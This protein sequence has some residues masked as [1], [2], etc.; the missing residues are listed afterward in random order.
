MK[1]I[2][3]KRAWILSYNLDLYILF[4]L[5]LEKCNKSEFCSYEKQCWQIV[6]GFIEKGAYEGNCAFMNELREEL[7]RNGFT[8]FCL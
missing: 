5:C 8:L 6:R 3:M 1:H 4:E 7:S 2:E